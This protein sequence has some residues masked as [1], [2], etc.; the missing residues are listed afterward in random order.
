MNQC[1]VADGNGGTRP[2]AEDYQ[3]AERPLGP[4]TD[5]LGI[6]GITPRAG[7][8]STRACAIGSNQALPQDRHTQLLEP[9]LC[10]GLPCPVHPSVHA[11]GQGSSLPDSQMDHQGPVMTSV[12]LSSSQLCHPEGPLPPWKVKST[13]G[14]ACRKRPPLPAPTH[15]SCL[16]HLTVTHSGGNI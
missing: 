6:G 5:S 2:N 3:M 11:S 12:M 13:Q 4:R 9:A 8:K 16:H 1:S 7:S 10:E 15:A 14:A